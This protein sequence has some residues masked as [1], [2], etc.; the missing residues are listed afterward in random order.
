MD[1]LK[2]IT[3]KFFFMLNDSKM[4]WKYMLIPRT[5]K[6]EARGLEI[7]GHKE[8]KSSLGY[9]NSSLDNNKNIVLSRDTKDEITMVLNL[10]VVT[11][12]G[13]NDP[14]TVAA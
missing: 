11:P 7:Q 13:S 9:M 1:I 3:W 8:F 2:E 4:C 6:M 5:Q 14:F 10:W 12:Q